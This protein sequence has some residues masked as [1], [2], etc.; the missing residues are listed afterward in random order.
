MDDDNVL[1]NF[2][3]KALGFLSETD[4]NVEDC[5]SSIGMS[6]I[7]QEPEDEQEEPLPWKGSMR[8]SSMK[9]SASCPCKLQN[10]CQM[11][12]Q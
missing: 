11:E 5:R 10:S 9:S 1:I 4:G 12:E 6:C 2:F 3:M 7:Y 8:Q